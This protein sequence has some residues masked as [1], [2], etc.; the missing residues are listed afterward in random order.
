MAAK[1]TTKKT[2]IE[3]PVDRTPE[4][5]KKL[6]RPRSAESKRISVKAQL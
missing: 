5:K 2:A 3:S 6:L 4:E 1:A